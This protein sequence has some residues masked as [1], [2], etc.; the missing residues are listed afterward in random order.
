M[1]PS[2]SV[3]IP[4]KNRPTALAAALKSIDAQTVRTDEVI[5]IDQSAGAPYAPINMPNH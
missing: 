2:L 4:T 3:I 1:P 5:V